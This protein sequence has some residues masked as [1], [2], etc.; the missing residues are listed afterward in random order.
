MDKIN[1]IEKAEKLDKIEKKKLKNLFLEN[2][3]SICVL[4]ALPDLHLRV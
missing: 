3:I 2:S 1:K 4:Q